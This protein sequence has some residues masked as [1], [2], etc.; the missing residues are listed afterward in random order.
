ML[1]A[2]FDRVGASS[3][4]DWSRTV[5]DNATK[6]PRQ[7]RVELE[8]G[9]WLTVQRRMFG[10]IPASTA[11]ADEAGVAH[12]GERVTLALPTVFSFE[13]AETHRRELREM[14]YG[15]IAP[16]AGLRQAIETYRKDLRSQMSAR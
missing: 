6:A 10:V 15:A 11:L 3:R 4:V 2:A 8:A 9:G 5:A 16:I 7:V 1:R 12:P 13:D 14:T